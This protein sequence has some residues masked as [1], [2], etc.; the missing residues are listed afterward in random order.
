MAM[1]AAAAAML[2]HVLGARGGMIGLCLHS[3]RGFWSRFSGGRR[4]PSPH[5]KRR[6]GRQNENTN[7]VIQSYLSFG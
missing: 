5:Q 3:G 2:A 6:S 1:V 7:Q 4:L